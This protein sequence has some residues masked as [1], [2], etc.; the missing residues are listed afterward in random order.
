MDNLPSNAMFRYV[1]IFSERKWLYFVIC[2]NMIVGCFKTFALKQLVTRILWNIYIWLLLKYK[3]TDELGTRSDPRRKN[4]SIYTHNSL[5]WRR[6][7]TNN[8]VV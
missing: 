5:S 4:I 7:K 1:L 8:C 2:L 6:V 3:T